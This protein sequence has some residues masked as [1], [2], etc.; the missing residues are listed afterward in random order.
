MSSKKTAPVKKT[1]A[2]KAMPVAKPRS[3]YAKG[4]RVKITRRD[5]TEV[6]SRVEYVEVKATGPFIFANVGTKDKPNV[7]GFRP[8]VVRGF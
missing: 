5:G 4:A 7:K 2:K 3:D 1:A 6:R 8:A